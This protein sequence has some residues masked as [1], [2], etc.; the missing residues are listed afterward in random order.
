MATA[1]VADLP[2]GFVEDAAHALPPGFVE[3]TAPPLPAGFVEDHAPLPE[4]F[5]LDDSHPSLTEQPDVK[6]F[7]ENSADTPRAKDEVSLL[8]GVNGS[9]YWAG[10]GTIP[11]GFETQKHLE[12]TTPAA[13][14]P[15][16]FLPKPEN[17]GVGSGVLRGLETTVEQL[18]TPKNIGLMAAVGSA[19]AAL[20]RAA[21][22]GFAAMMAK[23][24]PKRISDTMEAG[25]PGQMAEAAT[26]T[27]ATAAMAFLAAKHGLTGEPAVRPSSVEDAAKPAESTTSVATPEEA[28]PLA[29]TSEA[30][31]QS[32]PK[33]KTPISERQPV[34]TDFLPEHEEAGS[35]KAEV[36][37]GGVP[38]ERVVSLGITPKLPPLFD[39]ITDA[40][41]GIAGDLP[42]GKDIADGFKGWL[43]AMAG[44]TFP[45]LTVLDR[46]L[47]EA[48]ARWISSRSAA[49][50][51]AMLFATKV[52]DG[53]G[54]DPVRF[55]AAL[56]EDNLRSIRNDFEVAGDEKA[57]NVKTLIGAK[58]SPF[59][60]ESEYQD[61]LTQPS[62]QAALERHKAMWDSVIEPQFKKAMSIDPNEELPARGLQ[63]GARINLNPIIEGEKQGDTILSAGQGSLTGTMRKKSVFGRQ[64]AGSGEAYGSNYF[65]I[66]AN[67]FGKQLETANKNHFEDTMVEKGFAKFDK[68]GQEIEINGR[69]AESYPSKR[70]TMITKDGNPVAQSK[71]FYIDPRIK[72]E[73]ESA[74]NI[75]RSGISQQ[76]SR[77]VQ[78]VA[79]LVNRMALAGLTD[80]TVH[81]SN[82]ASAL[83]TRPGSSGGLITDTLL[84]SLGRSDIPVTIVKSI[85]KGFSEH[86]EQVKEL[87]E[88]GA[89]REPHPTGSAINPLN[90][91]GKVIA[92]AD[93]TTRLSLDDAY[94]RMADAGIVEKS[95]TNRRE[96][97]N[98]VGQYN[99]R[100]QGP[101]VR[102][103]R[104]SGIAP[105][106]TAGKTF[107][108]LAI[109][110]ATLDPGLKASS[111]AAATALRANQLSK[112]V[113]AAAL[114]GT[115]N[116]VITGKTT[117][118][119]G[120]PIGSIDTGKSDSNN[121]PLYIKAFDLM[122]LGRALRATGLRGALEAKR[123]GLTPQDALDSSVRDVVNT[124]VAPGLGPPIHTAATAMNIPT[125]MGV[126]KPVPAVAPGESQVLANLK[127]AAIHANP[128]IASI[129]DRLKTGGSLME[130]MQRQLPRYLPQSGKSDEFMS[131]YPEIV[132]RAQARAFTNDV[133]G[134]A[135]K[136]EP[137]ARAEFIQEAIGRLAPEDREQ[138]KRTLKYSHL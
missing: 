86:A 64:A 5:V 21:A 91:G 28:N 50:P 30:A 74:A 109:R 7:L 4:G 104:E 119:P 12:A 106:V 121:R 2:A 98:Q 49:K 122:G 38:Q 137:K 27:A 93:K 69:K 108:A 14:T 33:P 23:E 123:N 129:A 136:M 40:M 45:R 63:T 96:F 36:M 97:V 10:D 51:S 19:P 48:G 54:I 59:K 115:L 81:I 87:S 95:E 80:A 88:I 13:D 70:Q 31:A 68:P 103:L 72:S 111:N 76:T 105:F 3:D 128:I 52:L 124:A 56:H 134:Q 131:K 84:S 138:F 37:S 85:M 20:Q 78:P 130:S 9:S 18:T 126:G 17:T 8:D 117:G 66:M 15:G 26:T 89:M 62:T 61:F 25:T 112:W 58:G 55:G 120:V 99:K 39:K 65:D 113:G 92:W 135:R 110:T 82:L 75:L 118:R 22:V 32:T 83:F 24:L 43:G 47:G 132:H 133:I 114:V 94:K 125:A 101:F 44:K 71:N 73:Y 100:A 67:T 46:D 116:Y 90:W 79:N 102:F 57:A 60:T 107:N 16:V 29:Q 77:V 53:L 11:V 35:P 127:Q 42:E 1:E 41:A 6:A 34:P